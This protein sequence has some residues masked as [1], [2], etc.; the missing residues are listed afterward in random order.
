MVGVEGVLGL[1]SDPAS[2]APWAG[3][4]GRDP[5][6]SYLKCSTRPDTTCPRAESWMKGMK[7]M[8]GMILV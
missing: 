7:G 5:G 4:L 1:G 8:K 3:G 6:S 2:A